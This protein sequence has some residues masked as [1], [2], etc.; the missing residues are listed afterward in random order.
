MGVKR[1][2]LK[3]IDP[4]FEKKGG[5]GTEIPIKINGNR[6]SPSFGLDKG[7]SS[8]EETRP[9]PVESNKCAHGE[10]RLVASERS[11]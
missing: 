2:L 9:H 4:I 10:R 6:S 5:G 7:V 11:P 1:Q 8:S 3:A